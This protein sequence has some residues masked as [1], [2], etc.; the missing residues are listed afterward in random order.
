MYTLLLNHKLFLSCE[1]IKCTKS[2]QKLFV[3][4]FTTMSFNIIV[5]DVSFTVIN[6][7]FA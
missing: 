7:S 1:K 5:F 6:V 4:H 2:A 3:K